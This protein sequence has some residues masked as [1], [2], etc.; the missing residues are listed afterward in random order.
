MSKVALDHRLNTASDKELILRLFKLVEIYG[1]ITGDLYYSFPIW[2][3]Y[4][5]K[6]FKQ[7]EKVSI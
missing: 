1:E 5:T 4:R 6:K 3:I 2:R 7:F